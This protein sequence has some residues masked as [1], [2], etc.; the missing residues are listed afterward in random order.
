MAVIPRP[1]HAEFLKREIEELK[2]EI[3]QYFLSGINDLYK[4]D[5]LH[6]GLFQGVSEKNGSIIIKFKKGKA[7]R[8][9]QP[10]FAFTLPTEISNPKTW[11]NRAYVEVREK[12]QIGSDVL[13]IYFFKNDSPDYTLVGLADADISFVNTLA[14]DTIIILGAKEPPLQYLYNLQQIVEETN[15][16]ARVS[17]VLDMDFTKHS[18]S[19]R[20]M[21][22]Q[23]NILGFILDHLSVEDELILQGPPGTGKTYLMAQFCASLLSTG[24]SVLVTSLTNRAL[25]ELAEKPA[26]E[27]LRTESKIAKTNLSS[28]EKRK[29]KGVMSAEEIMPVK[30]HLTLATY[31]K[32]SGKAVDVDNESIFD[33]VI[34]EEASQSFLATIAA[35]KLLGRKVLLVGDPQQLPPIVKQ[36]GLDKLHP[37]IVSVV[38]GLEAYAYNSTAKA[39]RKVESYRLPQ[40]AVD[41]TGTFYEGTLESVSSSSL[42]ISLKSSYQQLFNPD[43][44]PSVHFMNIAPGGNTPYEAINLI[45][46][47]ILELHENEPQLEIA[48]LSPF[49]T[50][51]KKLQ[52]SIYNKIEDS[53]KITIE[54]IDRIQGLTS[55]V[56]LYLIP[57]NNFD[58]C[59][60]LNRF[61][62]ATSRARL[63]T[64]IVTDLNFKRMNPA[65]GLVG[66]YWN[67][68]VTG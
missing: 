61:N 65:S 25:V 55:D 2:D 27:A 47:I 18:W 15:L 16:P 19:P 58:F 42:P 14:K 9:K 6:V 12:A 35:A 45:Q 41:Y 36:K 68:L 1:I 10:Y 38:K 48:V 7:P 4:A 3:R 40:R 26:L 17:S 63:C 13:P 30:G 21:R 32:M 67:R 49:V 22:E 23:D 62:V 44:G 54:T 57:Y 66:E 11:N 39:I 50:T 56:T 37:N 33:Y 34:V 28:D 5:K 29:L 52:E 43:G 31:Y 46:Q 24:S 53:S 20:V 51:A 60:N 59:F 8:I 64:L